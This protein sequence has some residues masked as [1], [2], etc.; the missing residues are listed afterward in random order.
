MIYTSDAYFLEP[1]CLCHLEF[2]RLL[3]ELNCEAQKEEKKIGTSDNSTI[4][5]EGTIDSNCD[6]VKEP[7]HSLDSFVQG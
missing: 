2:S 3:Y 1:G 5:K 6:T 4:F 7:I